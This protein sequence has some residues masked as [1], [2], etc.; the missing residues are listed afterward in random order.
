[1]IAADLYER[2]RWRVAAPVRLLRITSAPAQAYL[3]L[4]CCSAGPGLGPSSI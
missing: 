2:W 4:V 1:M 3:L